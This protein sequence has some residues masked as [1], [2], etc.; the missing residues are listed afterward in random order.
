MAFVS[1][2]NILTIYFTLLSP[3]K[4]VRPSEGENSPVLTNHTGVPFHSECLYSSSSRF[5][6][7]GAS[8]QTPA[9]ENS[10]QMQRSKLKNK[11]SNLK[12]DGR[13]YKQRQTNVTQNRIQQR[14]NYLKLHILHILA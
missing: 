5:Q 8:K 2:E 9:T 12:P 1:A 4:T 14:L 11:I 10:V 3:G 6:L 7:R 13:S